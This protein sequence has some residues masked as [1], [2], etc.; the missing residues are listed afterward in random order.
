MSEEGVVQ[1]LRARGRLSSIVGVVGG[2]QLDVLV[3]RLKQEYGLRQA[4]PLQVVRWISS[5]NLARLI[6]SRRQPCEPCA[7]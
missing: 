4:S 3:E 2:F 7:R 5:E 1:L 6:A